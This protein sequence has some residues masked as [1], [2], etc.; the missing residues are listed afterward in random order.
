MVLPLSDRDL[1]ICGQHL[2]PGHKSHGANMADIQKDHEN[3]AT[4]LA[5]LQELLSQKLVIADHLVGNHGNN[6]FNIRVNMMSVSRKHFVG[7]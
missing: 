7:L 5:P 4:A 6:L 1:T 3:H 2:S